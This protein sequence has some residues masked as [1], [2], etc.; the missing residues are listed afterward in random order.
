MKTLILKITIF[1]LNDY[2]FMSFNKLWK[3]AFIP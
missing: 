1:I 3:M 2:H